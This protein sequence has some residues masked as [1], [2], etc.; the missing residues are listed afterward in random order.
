M[1]ASAG[2]D[3]VIKLWTMYD[4]EFFLQFIVPKEECVAIAMHQFK[5]F[6]V[7][8]FTDGFLRFFEI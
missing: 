4:S 2:K 5:L 1:I 3:G 8:S 6:M 7:A